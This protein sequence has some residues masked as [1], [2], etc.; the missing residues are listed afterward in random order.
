M[1]LSSLYLDQ[2][3]TPTEVL[4]PTLPFFHCCDAVY[5]QAIIDEQ[6]LLPRHC[7]EYDEELLYLF[8]GRPAYK[9]KEPQNSTLGCFMPLCFIINYETVVSIKRM[10]GFDSGAF[11]FYEKHMHGSMTR[12]QFELTPQKGAEKKVVN[13][14]HG[15]NDDY[16]SGKA[17]AEIDYDKIHFQVGSY[18]SLITDGGKTDVDDRKATIEVQL[19]TKIPLNSDTIETVILP[20][21]I[22]ESP[23]VKPFFET[24]NIPTIGIP[25]YGVASKLYY[26][27]LLETTR[28]YLIAK[29]LLNGK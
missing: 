13:F 15:N 6:A 12:E 9:S 26:V 27:Q 23:T 3:I 22:A 24:L 25:N 5:L 17:K 16:F 4:L 28:T 19:N 2:R 7:K 11:S 8:Y 1:A 14:F 29:K 10:L 20:K 21:H 18:H